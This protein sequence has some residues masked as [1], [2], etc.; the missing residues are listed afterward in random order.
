VKPIHSRLMRAASREDSSGPVVPPPLAVESGQLQSDS[1]YRVSAAPLANDGIIPAVIVASWSEGQ[2]LV[3]SRPSMDPEYIGW[4]LSLRGYYQYQTRQKH[5]LTPCTHWGFCRIDVLDGELYIAGIRLYTNIGSGGPYRSDADYLHPMYWHSI[6]SKFVTRAG[7]QH[8]YL[9]HVRYKIPRS[10]Q[11]YVSHFREKSNRSLTTSELDRLSRINTFWNE[12]STANKGVFTDDWNLSAKNSHVYEMI[13]KYMQDEDCFDKDL[14][15][16]DRFNADVELPSLVDMDIGGTAAKK[17]Y[18]WLSAGAPEGICGLYSALA[19]SGPG[20]DSGPVTSDH[21]DAIDSANV[22][23]E[24]LSEPGAM[25]PPEI[26]RAW[27]L[28]RKYLIGTRPSPGYDYI[29]WCLKLRGCYRYKVNKG[30]LQDPL[31]WGYAVI[32]IHDGELFLAGVRVYTSDDLGVERQKLHPIYWRS[33]F[34]KFVPR[35]DGQHLYFGYVAYKLPYQAGG[36][37]KLGSNEGN[38]E[39]DMASLGK[40]EEFWKRQDQLARPSAGAEAMDRVK[41]WENWNVGT[42]PQLGISGYMRSN[43]F[44]EHL[45]LIEKVCTKGPID[46]A[47]SGSHAQDLVAMLDVPVDKYRPGAPEF[48]AVYKRF[49]DDEFGPILYAPAFAG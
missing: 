43:E 32:D 11:D 15:L 23:F 45:R 39:G 34:S 22:T 31:V 5:N 16:L 17:R 1:D 7:G 21:A 44:S 25:T 3:A 36:Y 48:K 10:N 38:C 20:S 19:S 37:A 4:S 41:T 24:R 40:I 42:Q 46:G 18:E 30:G 13:R 2:Y 35:R 12:I 26:T 28:D 6:F 9:A 27:S 47:G 14:Q 29:G 33:A 8:L 49:S